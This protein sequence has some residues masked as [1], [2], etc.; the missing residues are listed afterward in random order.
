MSKFIDK[1]MKRKHIVIRCDNCERI[2]R[3]KR[4]NCR[5]C[6]KTPCRHCINDA[7]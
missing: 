7:K 3:E 5:F 1:Y 4:R 2:K 6:K